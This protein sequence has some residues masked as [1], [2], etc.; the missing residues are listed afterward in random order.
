[1]TI[2]EHICLNDASEYIFVV[3]SPVSEL[4]QSE[5]RNGQNLRPRS[6]E[7]SSQAPNTA[8]ATYPSTPRVWM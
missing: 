6:M 8:A 3:Y 5:A 1:M 4:L 7:T 2:R